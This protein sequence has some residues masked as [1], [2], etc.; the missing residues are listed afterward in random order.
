[1]PA[2]QARRIVYLLEDTA[3]YGGVKVALEQ[4]NLLAGR[5]WDV[6]VASPG[7]PPDWL[8]LEAKFARLAGFAPEDIPPA[9][10]LVATFWTTLGAAAAAQRRH[11]GAVVHLCQGF[12]GSNE[13]NRADHP[14]IEAAYRAPLPAIVVAAHLA[15]LLAERFGRPA[16]VVPPALGPGLRPA[17][18]FSPARRPRILV[19]APWEFYLKGV[20]VALAAIAELRRRGLPA[21]SIRLSQWP[22][23]AE[24]K[25][26]L[27][28]DEFHQALPPSAVPGLLR[29]CDLLL[30]PSWPQEGFGL[31]ALEAMACGVPVIASDIP[32]Y[33]EYASAAR[34]VPFDDPLAFAAAAEELLR[35]GASWR[36]H[37]RQGLEVAAGFS[38]ERGADAL[39]AAVGWVL[40][41]SWRRE[42]KAPAE[43]ELQGTR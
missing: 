24:E 34:L 14:A 32:S 41:G 36:R 29:G 39:E 7:P 8:P 43:L 25:A 9:E 6:T 27:P 28:P 4:A 3:L 5:G 12:E 33:R 40:D 10:L 30:A 15:R 13:H 11:G 42:L 19:V 17:L 26:L 31:P 35:D 38:R 1:M 16:R 21:R 22:L 23:S 18:R 20:P 2:A 37:R